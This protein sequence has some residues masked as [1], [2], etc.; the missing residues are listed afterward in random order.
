MTPE[1]ERE[2]G[3]LFVSAVEVQNP[4]Q[5]LRAAQ[6]RNTLC[7]VGLAMPLWVVHDLGALL[8]GPPGRIA[9]RAALGKQ[10]AQNPA[11]AAAYAT[12]VATLEEV[13]ATEMA[14]RSRGWRL[15][16]DLVSVVLLRILSPI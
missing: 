11:L 10:L 2:L 1:Q 8:V 16:D 4:A 5:L 12:W 14:V 6:W 13:A 15:T 7:R 9:A 3:G